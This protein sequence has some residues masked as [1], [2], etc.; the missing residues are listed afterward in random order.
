MCV[1]YM[2]DRMCHNIPR[3]LKA[4]TQK[5]TLNLNKR[6]FKSSELAQITCT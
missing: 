5:V 3:F 4:I 2:V 6:F 1:I